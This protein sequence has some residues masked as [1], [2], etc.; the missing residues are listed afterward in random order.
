MIIN[1]C[2]FCLKI[3]YRGHI[4]EVLFGAVDEVGELCLP[5]VFSEDKFIPAQIV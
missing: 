4:R 3:R 2:K 1:L 5:E